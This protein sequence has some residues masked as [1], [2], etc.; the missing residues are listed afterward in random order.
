MAPQFVN[1]RKSD[2]LVLFA[3]A[4]RITKSRGIVLIVV[5]L[6]FVNTRNA[7]TNVLIA[8]DLVSVFTRKT[9]FTVFLAKV[10]VSVNTRRIEDTAL[11][12]MG[13]VFAS[14]S[15]ED[16]I[17]AYAKRIKIDTF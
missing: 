5:V 9:N 11:N 17:V 14:I 13:R 7:N 6:L 4:A 1:I 3:A 10:L 16:I 12:V 2:I 15:R 8:E